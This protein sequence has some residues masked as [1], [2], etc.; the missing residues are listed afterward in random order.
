V[1]PEFR[2][3]PTVPGAAAGRL[4]EQDYWIAFPVEHRRLRIELVIEPSGTSSYQRIRDRKQDPHYGSAHVD[5]QTAAMLLSGARQARANE[6]VEH[7][8]DNIA[9]CER[10]RF[11]VIGDARAEVGL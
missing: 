7:L 6:L 2:A 5:T 8:A 3:L 4:D 10:L 1:F 11:C 9:F